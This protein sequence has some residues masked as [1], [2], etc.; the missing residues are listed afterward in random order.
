M[1]TEDDLFVFAKDHSI[2]YSEVKR[3]SKLSQTQFKVDIPDLYIVSEGELTDISVLYV[4]VNKEQYYLYIPE[5][6]NICASLHVTGCALL[7]C[8][9]KHQKQL[10]MVEWVER[11]LY[12]C[13]YDRSQA[14]AK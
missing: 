13:M 11:S 12:I 2:F 8:P 3:A 4:H 7:H 1:C 9:V 6:H 5:T 10:S 14:L